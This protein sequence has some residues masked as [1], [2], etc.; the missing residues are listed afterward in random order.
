MPG[1]Q[2]VVPVMNARY[3]LNAANA[4]WGSLYDA[5]YG[6]DAMGDLPPAGGYSAERGA[7]V[8]AWAKSSWMPSHRSLRAV[9]PTRR[10]YRVAGGQLQVDTPQ[11][12]TALANPALFAG[13]A[14]DAARP[15]AI[16]L[17]Q[18]GLH[19]EIHVDRANRIGKTDA[20][21]VADVCLEAAIT[22]IM[23]CEDS[24]AAVDA[25]DKA[26]AYR[27][28]LGLMRG[29]LVEKVEKGGKTIDR[30]HE[31]RSP[32]HRAGRRAARAAR[33]AR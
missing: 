14:G 22:T 3:A 32:L 16:L 33:A 31:S 20:A 13:H 25:D 18:H 9:M 23:D 6:T 4:R 10:R 24:V 5:L 26:H 11:G 2:L 30:A 7:R 15:R 29:D 12:T 21:G 19:V 1:P 17:R 28:W 8:I 27:N